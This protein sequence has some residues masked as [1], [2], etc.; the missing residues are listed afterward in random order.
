M[1]A[2]ISCPEISLTVLHLL[3]LKLN[4]Y[5]VLYLNVAL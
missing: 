1:A 3:S 2:E 5:S 4:V